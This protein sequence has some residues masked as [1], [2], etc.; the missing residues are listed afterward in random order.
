MVEQKETIFDHWQR[1]LKDLRI[2]V[3]DRCNFRCHYCMPAEI[4]GPDYP[5]LKRDE[6][7]SF[8]ELNRLVSLFHR[9]TSLQKL[10][11]TGG[12]PLMRKDLPQ[13]ISLLSQTTKIEDIA[14]TTNGV[15]LPRYAK[16]L[17]EAGLKRV[18]VSLDSLD[19]EKFGK[20]NG[21]GIGI[22]PVLKG[23]QAASDAGL[24]VKVN[25]VVQKGVNDND[26]IPMAKFFREKGYMLRFIE[27]MDVGTSNGWKYD[28]VI[29]KQEIIERINEDMPLEAIKPAYVG[30][31]ASRFKYKGSDDEVGVI[32]SVSDAFCHSCT[33]ARLSVE[34]S[35]YTCLFA[36]KG[37]DF[38]K[39]IRGNYSDED[40][41]N[42]IKNC[43]N[44]R[45]DR[46]SAERSLDGNTKRE[47]IEMSHI[48]G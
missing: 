41:M 30:E 47:K 25:M 23:M 27:Y 8:E 7:L 12:E 5:F 14:M 10:R 34:G 11:I 20:I 24:G 44:K 17:K 13:L 39:L 29:T 16:E 40:I 36:T 26:I 38:K 32:S 31:V 43:W 1:P 28:E 35:L 22:E 6:L 46:Y 45:D 33:R 21:R 18:T 37:H 15:F 4:F 2:S 19:S 9:V 48:G 42:E 3:T